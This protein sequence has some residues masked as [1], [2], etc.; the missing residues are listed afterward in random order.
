ME[1][2]LLNF[3][4]GYFLY[5][6]SPKPIVPVFTRNIREAS[7]SYNGYLKPFL[8]WLYDKTRLPV[9]PTFGIFPVKLTTY[10]GKPI[11][12]DESLGV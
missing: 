5:L 11:P 9:V 2:S 1:H 3:T 4:N 7:R 12:F 8:L 6:F 10:I